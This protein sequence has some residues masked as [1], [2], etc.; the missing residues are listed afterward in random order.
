MKTTKMAVGTIFTCLSAILGVIG[1]IFYI[2]NTNTAYFSNNGKS[3][4]VIACVLLGVACEVVYV[5][6]TRNGNSMVTDL[7]PILSIVFLLAGTLNF[8]AS[9]IAGIAS[10]MTFEMN[11]QNMAD[12]Q[13]AIIGMVLLLIASIV[14]IIGNFFDTR[15]EV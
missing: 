1:F 4:A 7:L 14:M 12:L 5:V 6:L 9:R 11:E 8:A 15:K 10:I 3:T 13:S 2:I